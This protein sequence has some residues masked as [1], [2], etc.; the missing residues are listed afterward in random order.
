MA[1]DPQE[2]NIRTVNTV[3]PLMPDQPLSQSQEVSQ[4]IGP[5]QVEE[6]SSPIYLP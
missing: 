6:S 4:P 3:S 1:D 2:H 5:S